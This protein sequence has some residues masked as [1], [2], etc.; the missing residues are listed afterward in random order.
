[1][2]IE[3]SILNRKKTNF[4]Q[5]GNRTSS[6]TSLYPHFNTHFTDS[7]EAH[8]SYLKTKSSII[9]AS[10]PMSRFQ[11]RFAVV[12]NFF[13]DGRTFIWQNNYL[14]RYTILPLA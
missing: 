4:K 13:T 12:T 10:E 14:S 8:L 5:F 7:G 3:T 9:V 11:E 2:N 1:M 6:L